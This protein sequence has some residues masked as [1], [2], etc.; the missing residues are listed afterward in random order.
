[1]H[2]GQEDTKILKTTTQMALKTILAPLPGS[3]DTNSGNHISPGK[4]NCVRF[5][6]C[7]VL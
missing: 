1:M 3:Y 5:R 6:V 4:Q 2:Q 7:T